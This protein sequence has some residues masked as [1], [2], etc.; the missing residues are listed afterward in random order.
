MHIHCPTTMPSPVPAQGSASGRW[1]PS[2]SLPPALPQPVL[3]G[4]TAPGSSTPTQGHAE[5]GSCWRTRPPRRFPLRLAG[6]MGTSRRHWWVLAPQPQ[7]SQIWNVE[8]M[9]MSCHRTRTA[10]SQ[11]RISSATWTSCVPRR[12]LTPRWLGLES[13]TPGF[14]G[15]MLFAP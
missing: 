1:V 15:E 13:E 6:S 5:P 12:T 8:R 10:A 9:D 3:Q 11:T 14:Q 7:G 4:N 2:L